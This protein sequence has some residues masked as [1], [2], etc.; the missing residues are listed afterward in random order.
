MK[1]NFIYGIL[2]VC[3]W[4]R[5]ERERAIDKER[6]R[7]IERESITYFSFLYLQTQILH[8]FDFTSSRAGGLLPGRRQATSRRAAAMQAAV[9]RWHCSTINVPEILCL[10]S[11]LC[12]WRRI[13][14]GR[15]DIAQNEIPDCTICQ[16]KRCDC[17]STD[18]S[19]RALDLSGNNNASLYATALDFMLG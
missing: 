8:K 19:S 4:V 2:S 17:D 18:I 7:Q 16:T 10:R 11:T 5:A 9:I 1:P 15:R 6:K 14:R 3:V 12:S 13:A